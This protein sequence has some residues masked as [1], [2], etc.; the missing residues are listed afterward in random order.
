MTA[1]AAG[2]LIPYITVPFG[3]YVL[4][5]GWVSL[6]LYHVAI[7]WWVTRGGSGVTF[8]A[9]RSGWR[10][11]EALVGILFGSLGGLVVWALWPAIG[12]TPSFRTELAAIGLGGAS[13]TAFVLYHAL[14]HPWLEELLWRGSLGSD[15]RHPTWTDLAFA[16]YHALVLWP[17]L[18]WPWVVVSVV[19]LTMAGW[20]WR[21]LA[22]RCGGLLVPGLSHAAGSASVLTAVAILTRS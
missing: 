6:L 21:M 12:L 19:N 18:A 11:R 7:V 15:V 8:A 2:A 16:G 5:S 10:T 14:V 17:F 13:F 22:L 3:L 20:F 4:H 1:R 9:L